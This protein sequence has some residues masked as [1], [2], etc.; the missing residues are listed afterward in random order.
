MDRR[1]PGAPGAASD[2]AEEAERFAVLAGISAR[3]AVARGD[4][5]DGVLHEVLDDLQIHLGAEGWTLVRSP[6]LEVMGTPLTPALLSGVEEVLATR[7]PVL[8]LEATLVVPTLV[9]GE[10]VGVLAFE[11]QSPPSWDP[12]ALGLARAVGDVIGGAIA[13][14]E[15]ESAA[16]RADDRYRRLLETAAEGV[17]LLDADAVIRFANRAFATLVGTGSASLDGVPLLRFLAGRD[18]SAAAARFLHESGHFEVEILRADKTRRWVSCSTSALREDVDGARALITMTDISMRRAAEAALRN[19]E[20][21]FRALVRSSSDVIV[22]TDAG[23][24]IAYASPSVVDVLGH[25]PAS[26][27]GTSPLDLVHP[28]DRPEVEARARELWDAR[29]GSL[30]L[31]CR[32]S[33]GDGRFRPMEA[34]LTNLIDD[35]AVSGMTITAR[36]ISEQLELQEALAFDANHDAVTG[37]PNRRVLHQLLS[38]AL[39]SSSTTGA[40]SVALLFA[41]LD[42]FKAVNDRFGHETGDE[43]LRLVGQRLQ[44]AVRDQ[45]VVIRHGGDEFAVLCPGLHERVEAEAVARR[46]VDAVREPLVID[47]HRIGVGVSIGIAGSPSGARGD[48]SGASGRAAVRRMIAEADEAMYRAKHGGLGWAFAGDEPDGPLPAPPAPSP[49]SPS[50]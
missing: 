38:D 5:L 27:K 29:G 48:G 41:D 13:R 15:A 45:D 37:L 19:S 8:A 23:G 42:G 21:R 31:R 40:P 22:V 10:I 44:A 16:R 47:G 35:R 32:L 2:A 39:R 6:D 12:D 20:A 14:R 34:V 49:P 50:A 11:R 24:A 36:D 17:C 30:V 9:A 4:A 28:D 1:P 46:L 25:D 43:V 3:L 26:L 33:C 7:L 18:P